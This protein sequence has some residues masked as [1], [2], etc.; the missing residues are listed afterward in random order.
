MSL[1]AELHNA[2]KARLAGIAAR[3]AEHQANKKAARYEP[4]P[5]PEPKPEPIEDG[6][7]ER[8][9]EKHKD[10]WFSIESSKLIVEKPSVPTIKDIQRATCRVFDV[11]MTDLLSSRQSKDIARP[12]QVSMYLARKLTA[13]SLPA[14]ARATGD[15]DHTTAIFA[16]RRIEQLC[17]TDGEL[18]EK[19]E[20]IR[21]RLP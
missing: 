17:K 10:Y 1:A 11:T 16:V 21:E 14:I 13:L 6:W 15:R 20:R 4:N 8:Q 9:I 3:A 7:V 18:A 5:K 12:R 2:H 19:V